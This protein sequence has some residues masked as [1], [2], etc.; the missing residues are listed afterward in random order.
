MISRFSRS[1]CLCLA[2]CLIFMGI[3]A[4]IDHWGSYGENSRVASNEAF[5]TSVDDFQ[6]VVLCT[7]KTNP[8]DGLTIRAVLNRTVRRI[9]EYMAHAV[10]PN[11]DL[12]PNNIICLFADYGRDTVNVTHYMSVVMDYIHHQDGRKRL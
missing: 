9:S 4:D 6:E 5:I 2:V 11:P 3:Y 7:G 10:V 12:L 1:I 8:G